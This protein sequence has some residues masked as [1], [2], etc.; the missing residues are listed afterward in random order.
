M[1]ANVGDRF[2][3]A[4]WR[5]LKLPSPTGPTARGRF[6]RESTL[7][8]ARPSVCPTSSLPDTD[9]KRIERKA[10]PRGQRSSELLPRLL[11]II[12]A[13]AGSL[14]A[15]RQALALCDQCMLDVQINSWL[16]ITSLD[17]FSWIA[18]AE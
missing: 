16:L 15:D 12:L 8:L 17:D 10:G 7:S 13:F 3:E 5:V 11:S 9:Q 14:I 18:A 1:D 2:D 4:A 6:A